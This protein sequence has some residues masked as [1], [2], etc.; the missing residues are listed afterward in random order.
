MVSAPRVYA[1]LGNESLW[2]VVAHCHE[3]LDKARI[4]HAIIGGVAV[5]LHGY[6]RNTVDV[7]LLVRAQDASSLRI[8]LENAGYAWDANAQ[9]FRS[10]SGIPV[11]IV[12]A[13]DRAGPGSEVR[14]PDPAD[15]SA[16]TELEGLPVVS[17]AKLIESKL[18]C[19]LAQLRRTHRDFADVVELIAVQGLDGSFAKYLHKSLRP[20]YRKLVRHAQG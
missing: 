16:L 12:L 2:A 10:K 5:C 13:E 17:L 4:D 7:D 20:T 14:M 6:Q 15:S 3:T 9:E 11:H 1:M 8:A 19:G 18:A